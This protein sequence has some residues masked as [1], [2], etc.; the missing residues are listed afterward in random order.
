MTWYDSVEEKDHTVV[1][2]ANIT[3][4]HWWHNFSSNFPSQ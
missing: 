2:F 3:V 4:H 1:W